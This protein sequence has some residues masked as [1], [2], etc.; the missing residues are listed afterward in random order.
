MTLSI[1]SGETVALI[2]E[3]GSGKSTTAR[4]A[5]RLHDPDSGVV[6]YDGR[7]LAS[8]SREELRKLRSDMT[9][10]FQEPYESLNPRQTVT[11]TVAEPLAIHEPSLSRRELSARV[12]E[13]LKHVALGYQF[14]DRYPHELSGGQQQRVGIARA[15]VTRPK[16]IVLDEPTS[17][18]DLSV[19]AQVL[20]LLVDLQHEFRLAYLFVSHDIQ[21]VEYISDRIGV[22]Y[23]G[24]IV[25]AGWTGDQGTRSATSIYE[26]VALLDL[27]RRSAGAERPVVAWRRNP[28]CDESAARLLPCRPL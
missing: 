20:Q 16:F 7:D 13:T 8:L 18:L 15:L 9:M 21:T 27:V 5:V 11:R 28:E 19:R 26:G 3:S 23:L 14:G 12:A 1:D 10:V 24:Q 17:S 6:E 22:M 2:G 25:E 4:L